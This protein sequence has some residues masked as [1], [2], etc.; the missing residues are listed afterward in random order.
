[1]R[2]PLVVISRHWTVLLSLEKKR[3]IG[4]EVGHDQPESQWFGEPLR[5]LDI[6]LTPAEGL[7]RGSG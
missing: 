5:I 1:M 6:G 7:S 4:D 3:H 2:P